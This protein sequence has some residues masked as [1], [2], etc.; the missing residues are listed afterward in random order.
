MVASPNPRIRLGTVTIVAIGIL[1][2]VGCTERVDSG[3]GSS[4]SA[5]PQQG[6]TIVVASASDIRGV[7]Q[8][9]GR[10]DAFTQSVLNR[11]FLSLLEERPDFADHPPT[12][13]PEIATSWKWSEDRL[14]LTLRLRDDLLWSDGVRLTAEDVVWTWQVQVSEEISW[15]QSTSKDNI[16]SMEAVDATT[17]VVRFKEKNDSQLWDLNEGVI[18]PKHAWSE[19]PLSEWQL[20][21]DWFADHL[22][23]SGPYRLETWERQQQI[24][25]VRNEKHFDRSLPMMDRIVFRIVPQELNRIGQLLSG[26]LDFVNNVSISEAGNTGQ[27]DDVVFQSYWSGRYNFICWNLNNPLFAK[28]QI[29]QALTMAID[30]QA[31]IDALLFGR[32]TISTSPILST[33]WAH[34]RALEPWP[35][36]PKRS[37][38]LLESQG[39]ADTND[40]GIIDKNG[41]PF[42]FEM[43]TNIGSRPRVD[44][45]IMIQEQLRRI[46]IEVKVRSME[47]KSLSDLVSSQDFDA[48][49]LG[50]AVDT[51]LDQTSIFHSDSIENGSNFGAYSNREVDRLIELA[52][53][54]LDLGHR[55][56]VLHEIQSLIHDDQPYTFLWESQRLAGIS[57]RVQNATPNALDPLFG[58]ENWWLL[59]DS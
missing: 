19:L 13:G 12:F 40:D 22:T 36:D 3:A 14:E 4:V 56:Q 59:P 9:V 20:D 10:T 32:A 24:I 7:N 11:L 38:V 47:F 53:T 23:V 5:L 35:Y 39:W 33:V 17:L 1:A 25:L 30:R 8:L 44:A 54:D 45:L 50:W 15:S 52:N 43:I 21:Q 58:I 42:T 28:R 41:Q 34:N 46:G 49:L 2:L 31:L 27:T 18:L 6:G 26:E 55:T 51:S 48:F 29:R 16:D 57:K 37:R